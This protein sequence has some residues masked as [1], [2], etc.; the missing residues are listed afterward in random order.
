VNKKNLIRS[1]DLGRLMIYILGRS[2]YEFGLVPD[3]E[4]FVPYKELL[5]AINEEPG[6][7]YVRWGNINEVLSGKERDLFLFDGKRIKTTDRQWTLDLS[8]PAQPTPKILFIGIRRKAH[9]VVMEKGLRKIE[10]SYYILSPE[11]EIA[12]RIGMRR[13]QRPVLLEIMAYAAQREGGLFYRFG[14]LF[15]TSDISPQHIAGPPVS[16]DAIK[17]RER[18]RLKVRESLPEFEAGSFTLDIKRDTD[19]MRRQP[20]RKKKSWKEEARRFRRKGLGK[21]F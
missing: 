1:E 18:K 21:P 7:G 13:D 10:G 5:R 6:W 16:K 20:G 14:D 3:E 12:R 15:L 17:E 9:P 19:K 11:R 4:G 8:R 2:P